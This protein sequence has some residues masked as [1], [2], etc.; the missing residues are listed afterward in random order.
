MIRTLRRK[1]I[2]IAMLSLIGTM[3]VLCIAI[4]VGNHF[5]AAGRADRAISMLYQNGG[6]FGPPPP[7]APFDPSSFEFQVTPETSFELR[8]AIVELTAR[9]EV[10]SVNT[11]HIAALDRQSV[12]ESIG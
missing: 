6:S 5:T 9:Q 4:G 3:A 8:Y 1:F 7:A 10:R 12:V 2:L 11:E